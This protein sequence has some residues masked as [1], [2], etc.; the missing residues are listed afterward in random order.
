MYSDAIAAPS[1]S[2][3]VASNALRSA[4]LIDKDERMRDATDKRAAAA[5]KTNSKI[6]SHKPRLI[7]S[8]KGDSHGHSGHGGPGPSRTSTVNT[9]SLFS[10]SLLDGRPSPF[11]CM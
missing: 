9:P 7:D 10:L 1:G 6:R 4:G 3:V 5:R 11:S 8:I 2:R